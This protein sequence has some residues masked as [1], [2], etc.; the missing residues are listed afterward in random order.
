MADISLGSVRH[1]REA[2]YFKSSNC[3]RKCRQ[4]TYKC[5]SSDDIQDG[6]RRPGSA[7]AHN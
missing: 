5:T 4:A 1:V 6:V 7:V 2:C 3:D